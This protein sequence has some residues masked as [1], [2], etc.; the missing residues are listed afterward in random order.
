MR[1]DPDV[2]LNIPKRRDYPIESSTVRPDARG[3]VREL[4]SQHGTQVRRRYVVNGKV[5]GYASYPSPITHRAHVG[6][7]PLTRAAF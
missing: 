6:R 5:E 3:S 7:Q 4:A 1:D 2:A